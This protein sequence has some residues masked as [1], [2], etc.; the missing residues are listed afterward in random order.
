M[1]MLYFTIDFNLVKFF[2]LL[3]FLKTFLNLIYSIYKN[4]LIFIVVF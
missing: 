2:V 1:D 4:N 3:S